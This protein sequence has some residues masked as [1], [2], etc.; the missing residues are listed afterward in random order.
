VVE[1]LRDEPE[2]LAIADA[3]I[4]TQTLRRRFRPWGLVTIVALVTVLFLIILA[5][6]HT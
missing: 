6:R 5:S 2:L 1:L 4:E 3:L